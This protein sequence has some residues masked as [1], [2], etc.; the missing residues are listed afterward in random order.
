LGSVVS[1]AATH[2]IPYLTLAIRKASIGLSCRRGWQW[3]S[4]LILAYK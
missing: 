3:M 1:W 2:L 4:A